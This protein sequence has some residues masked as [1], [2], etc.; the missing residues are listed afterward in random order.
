MVDIDIAKQDVLFWI[1]F[2]V[3]VQKTKMSPPLLG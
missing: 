1:Y 2:K 3:W